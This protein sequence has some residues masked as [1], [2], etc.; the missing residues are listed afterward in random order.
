MT[1]LVLCLAACV[2][3]VLYGL[4]A[5]YVKEIKAKEKRPKNNPMGK[6]TPPFSTSQRCSQLTTCWE[7]ADALSKPHGLLVSVKSNVGSQRF[8]TIG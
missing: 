8:A 7:A 4:F 1:S 5:G 6:D 2:K 3:F